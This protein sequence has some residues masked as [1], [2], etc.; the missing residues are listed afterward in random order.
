M[1]EGYVVTPQS[2]PLH[3]LV[4]WPAVLAGAA[5]A[6]TVGFMLNLLGAALGAGTFDTF[7]L[8]RA[9]DAGPFKAAAGLWV[10]VANAIALF[11]GAAAAS[12][13][14]KYSDNH[15]GMLHG[16]SVWAVAFFIAIMIATA[17]GG[18]AAGSVA[19]DV[20]EDAASSLGATPPTGVLQ[21]NGAY[22]QPDG[23]VTSADGTVIG[24]QSPTAATAA[25][26]TTAP[27]TPPVAPAAPKVID[28]TATIAFWGFL[29]MLFGAIGAVLG[30]RY[31]ARHH[32]WEARLAAKETVVRTTPPPAI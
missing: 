8:A 32:K 6:V 16:L 26:L 29:G 27:V 5:I 24:N 13:A 2:H 22:L 21:S 7:E 3:T 11:A 28:A 18:G 19:N 1:T 15:N 20:T 25:P 31:G 4:S 30:G 23:T 9:G 14:A 10:A 12:R 17:A